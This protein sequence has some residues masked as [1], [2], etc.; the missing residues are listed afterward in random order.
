[1]AIPS[2]NKC[3]CYNIS[4]GWIPFCVHPCVC[5]Y[6]YFPVV[7]SPL[8]LCLYVCARV[9]PSAVCLSET[10]RFHSTLHGCTR[11]PSRGCEVSSG[12]R[13]QSEHSNWGI[14]EP[15]EIFLKSNAVP[16]TCPCWS[17]LTVFP[18]CLVSVSLSPYTTLFFSPRAYM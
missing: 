16:Q 17:K 3:L 6:D 13:S 2:V 14:K 15:R 18:F 11:K 9:R 7:V 1:M 12:E 8:L 4:V 10:E 5:I